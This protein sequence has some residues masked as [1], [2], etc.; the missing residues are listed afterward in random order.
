MPHRI[1]VVKQNERLADVEAQAYGSLAEVFE[2]KPCCFETLPGPGEINQFAGTVGL[3]LSSSPDA[4]AFLQQLRASVPENMIMLA[5]LP[6][7]AGT[8]T[9]ETAA[10][11]ADDFALWPMQ[12]NELVL[13]MRWLLARRGPTAGAVS[14][15]L[16]DELGLAQLV[17]NHPL[18]RDVLKK[19]PTLARSGEPVLI[20]GETGTGKELSARALHHLSPRRDFPFIAVDCA[21]LPDH[22]VENELFGHAR[23][24]FTDAHR[25]QRGLIAM[26]DRGT[27]F[28]D[29]VDAL[30]A[31]VQA[32]LLRFLQ[33]RTY[34]PLGSDKFRHADIN[35]L[36]ASNHDLENMVTLKQFRADLFY[37]LSAFRMVLP[38]LRDRRSDIALLSRYFLEQVAYRHE[39]P[40]K[41]FSVEA[42]ARLEA[43]SWPGNVR[44]L[45]NIVRQAEAFAHGPEIR[46]EELE[47]P[48]QPLP[49]EATPS[50]FKAARA[51]AV[52][53]FEKSF[54][55][56]LLRKHSG[57]VTRAAID[58]RKDRRTFGRLMK[59]Y[60]IGRKAI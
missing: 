17:G 12:R 2:V 25:D 36:A 47:I 20:L 53:L 5:V 44:E 52:E 9:L 3:A 6:E 42:M 4:I 37:R 32:K 27:L 56:D 22:L 54:I 55:T 35:V 11:L 10:G 50:S 15:R 24:A 58:A 26:A 48:G 18:F 51:H 14:E 19:M 1:L 43:Y 60:S 7:A 49:A 21:A 41:K 59:K 45:S 13:R 39:R 40:L 16:I 46:A 33:E 23:G 28:L 38:A 57:N 30:P 34:K 31:P 8:E 29:E